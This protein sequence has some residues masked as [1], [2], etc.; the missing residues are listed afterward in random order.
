MIQVVNL[1]YR[2]Y[3]YGSNIRSW[4]VQGDTKEYELFFT[5]K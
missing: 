2:R 1:E 5:K 3:D 4:W